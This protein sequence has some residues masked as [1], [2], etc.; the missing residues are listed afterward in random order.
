MNKVFLFALLTFA[1]FA[2]VNAQL[3]VD[4]NGKVKIASNQIDSISL[5]TVGNNAYTSSPLF[6]PSYF[7]IL[8]DAVYESKKRFLADCGN[9]DTAS[10]EH[11]VDMSSRIVNPRFDNNDVTTGWSGTGFQE[12]NASDNAECYMTAFTNFQKIDNL[13]TGVYAIGAK[14]FYRAGDA[15]SAYKH[16]KANDEASCYARLFSESANGY[17]ESSIVSIF[18][19]DR[20]EP[21]GDSGE[22]C[23]VDDETS[24]AY[25]VPSN[26]SMGERY[27]HELGLYDNHVLAMVSDWLTLG[28]KKDAI[29]Y[30][31]WCL[32]DDFSLIYYGCGAD[33][34]QM[35]LNHIQERYEHL[36]IDEH[37]L[38]TEAYLL[39][40]N[41]HRTATTE[42]EVNNAL[43][44]IH[45]AYDLLQ[46]NI[47][48]WNDWKKVVKR[49]Q[50]LSSLSCFSDNPQTQRLANYCH[51]DATEIEAAHS[52]TNVQLEAE[53]LEV[54]TM[55]DALYGEDQNP[56]RMLKDG[57]QWIYNRQQRIDVD[58]DIIKI[59]T[60]V[61]FTLDGDTIIGDYRYA[62]LYRQEENENPVY[63]MA[64]RE[65]GTTI[66]GYAKDAAEEERHME[67]NPRFFNETNIDSQFLGATEEIDCV[68][69]DGRPFVRHTYKIGAGS[70]I[71][72]EGVGYQEKGILDMNLENLKS[73]IISFDSCYE[74]GECIFTAADFYKPGVNTGIESMY[75][76]QCTMNKKTQECSK[77]DVLFDL[78]GR[79]IQ[80]SPKH[81]VYI[82]K[83]KKVM[84][85]GN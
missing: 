30:E 18:E 57:K 16:Y 53:I 63:W 9:Y 69:V 14:A 64:L 58:D 77:N 4:A 65:D 12:L 17:N 67:F 45:H 41:R 62:K 10:V 25:W 3:K 40:V 11:P 83:G 54:E 47:K 37:T 70:L 79:R 55:I 22:T 71:A 38:F 31:D 48:L 21:L 51:T 28:V 59:E 74:D 24:I 75:N 80:G 36:I 20:T 60:K 44:D 2:E 42:A 52:L 81:G 1:S 78:Q 46:K 68:A 85:L 61:A 32:F 8:G 34:Y 15:L 39:E 13:P 7:N 43:E 29:L 23:V 6:K 82:Q 56:G 50:S 19:G 72:V 33:A 26:M 76:E 84:K 73:D 35:Y 66:Y 5:L 49:G 27:M